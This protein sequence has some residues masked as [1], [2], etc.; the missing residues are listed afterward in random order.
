MRLLTAL[1]ATTLAFAAH[2]Q[3]SFEF[4]PGAD[5]DDAVPTIESVVGHA[6]GERIT[7]HADVV[8]YFEAL[9]EYDPERVQVHRYGRTWEGRD[10]I[11]AV[12]SSRG[13]MARI[14]EIKAAMQRLRN[15]GV[16]SSAEANRIIGAY[17]A[18]T[19]LSYGVHGNEISST[20][21]AMLTAY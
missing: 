9:A 3:P 11:Y 21:A 14:D 1:A 17:P 5:Y 18:V 10:L 7:W 2:A 4:W 12:I 20:D 15:A 13:N 19:W 16:T 6:P 8:R